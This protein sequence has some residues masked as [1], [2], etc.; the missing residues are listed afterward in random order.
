M[1][2]HAKGFLRK[3][4]QPAAQTIADDVIHVLRGHDDINAV[5]LL[6]IEHLPVVRIAIPDPILVG[7]L[8]HTLLVEVADTGDLHI[9][10]GSERRIMNLI[11]H[12]TGTDHADFHFFH[13]IFLRF[14]TQGQGSAW[15]P[16]ARQ[17]PLLRSP[18]RSCVSSARPR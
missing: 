3:G 17:S 18:A 8:R 7:G 6:L 12:H 13:L 1:Q 14:Q 11:R 16:T 4:V 9:V 2:A 15:D 5:R 10:K